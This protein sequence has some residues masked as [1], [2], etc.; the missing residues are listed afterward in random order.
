MFVRA[1]GPHT[2]AGEGVEWAAGLG[3]EYA[4]GPL[5]EAI[6]YADGSRVTVNT[7][8]SHAV[9]ARV[10]GSITPLH[11]LA[12][13]FSLPF[14]L[15]ETGEKGTTLGG[16]TPPA[17]ERDG[18]IGDLRLGVHF[19]PIDTRTL[20]L[21]VGGRVWAPFGSMQAYLSD[22]SFRGEVEVGVAGE[23]SRFLYGC[24][25]SVAPTF[26]IHHSG[27]RVS[28]ACAAHIMLGE[29][30]SIGVEPS[31]A[32]VT[33]ANPMDKASPNTIGVLVEPLAALRLRLGPTRLG[34]AVG[35]GFGGGMGSAEVRALFTFAY[36][37]LGKPPP[38]PVVGPSDRDLDG[39]PDSEDACP[40]EAGPRSR[41]PKMNGCPSHDR[42]G[43]GIRDDEDYCPDRAGIPYPDPKANGC[44]DTDNDG[45]PDPIDKCVNEPGPP[46]T[47]CPKYARLMSGSFKVDPPIEFGA[48]EKL[49]PE[50]RAAIEEI[51][52]TMRANPKIEQVSIAVGTKG[53]RPALSDKRAQEILLILRAGG[54]LDASRY[55]VVLRDDLRAGTV[56][57]RLVK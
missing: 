54:N 42:D 45:L 14:A 19:R 6:A 35:P 23:V 21:I 31:F 30:A 41:D 2:P 44:P 49:R 32:A 22:H 37:G 36:V 55:E 39:I 38:P 48:G 33:H 57:V 13:D 10:S 46:P 4:K 56:Q 12:F 15:F 9:L 7:L 20:G 53:V 43:D 8:V 3:F 17:G 52:A 24:T 11:W 29:V 18:S 27:D 26:F 34:L 50:G 1:E 40:D 28:A 51:A 5:K 25:L 16:V 47:G